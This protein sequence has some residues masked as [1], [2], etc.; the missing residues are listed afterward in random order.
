[1]RIS[2]CVYFGIEPAFLPLAEYLNFS[3]FLA[4]K[5]DILF[6][7]EELHLKCGKNCL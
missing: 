2:A 6:L 4:V 5:C 7:C 3:L 1:M